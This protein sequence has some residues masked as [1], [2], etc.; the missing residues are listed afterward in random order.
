MKKVLLALI[1]PWLFNHYWI[2]T[3]DPEIGGILLGNNN[4]SD[5]SIFLLDDSIFI[6]CYKNV[7]NSY[8]ASY[9]FSYFLFIA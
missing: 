1:T 5:E 4:K 3:Y 9:W 6:F 8:V 2:T 7:L